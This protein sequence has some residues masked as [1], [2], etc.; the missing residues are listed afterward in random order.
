MGNGLG[1]GGLA[2][3]RPTNANS[4]CLPGST[5][6]CASSRAACC[7]VSGGLKLTMTAAR[8]Y[9]RRPPEAKTPLKDT[10]VATLV[11]LHHCDAYQGFSCL[12][13]EKEAIF[14][15]FHQMCKGGIAL[16]LEFR[17]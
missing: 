16:A 17:W 15:R 13:R 5:Q 7:R 11:T 1:R 10:T 6:T 12:F 9:Q 14:L 4:T 2:V 3:M 8:V